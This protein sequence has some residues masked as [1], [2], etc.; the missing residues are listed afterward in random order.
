[1][2]EAV[3][4]YAALLVVVVLV[5]GPLPRTSTG[6]GTALGAE[7]RLA[8]YA[9]AGAT[10]VLVAFAGLRYQVGTD[11]A[12][13]TRRFFVAGHY[14]LA[15]AFSI[16]NQEQAFTWLT[17]L[18]GQVGGPQT[19]FFVM[20]LVTVTVTVWSLTGIGDR[21]GWTLFF[22]LTLGSYFAAFNLVRQSLAIALIVFAW[23]HLDRRKVAC[24]VAIGC[25][26]LIHI[27]AAPVA[28]VLWLSRRLRPSRRLLAVTAAGSL[29]VWVAGSTGLIRSE[30]FAFMNPNW[31]RFDHLWE[32]A[33]AGSLMEL[34][35]VLVL[36][37]VTLPWVRESANRW[38]ARSWTMLLFAPPGLALGALNN[39]APRIA[40]YFLTF[41]VPLCALW[42][43]A[44]RRTTA[45]VVTAAI[46]VGYL[47]LMLLSGRH[48]LLP[49]Q[50]FFFRETL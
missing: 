24:A 36:L 22:Y 20:A 11:F 48:S 6:T 2:V 16:A 38:A 28:G 9:L 1:M 43:S 40:I 44:R 7:R 17:R 30:W 19:F 26:A 47:A 35:A 49:Y 31:A 37:A 8:A 45:A 25:A 27:T 18:L 12:L 34:V 5:T 23:R 15:E 46:A 14:T 4:P 10:A 32:R 13:N 29:L 50:F 41:A 42:L 21:P 3:L 33:G 39:Q